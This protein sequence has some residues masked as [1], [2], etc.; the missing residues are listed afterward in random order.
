MPHI[1]NQGYK[2]TLKLYVGFSFLQT[3]ILT[4][5]YSPNFDKL[6]ISIIVDI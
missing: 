1:I 5:N 3:G 2:N 4:F 6:I